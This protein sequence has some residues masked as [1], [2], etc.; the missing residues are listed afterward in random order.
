[1][2]IVSALDSWG[3]ASDGERIALTARA[4]LGAN[5]ALWLCAA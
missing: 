1:V 5:D 3:D 2:S 4:V